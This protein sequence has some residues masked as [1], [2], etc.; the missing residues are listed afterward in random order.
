[1]K[2]KKLCKRIGSNQTINVYD[3]GNLIY[4][5]K[6]PKVAELYG[7]MKVKYVSAWYIEGGC[8]TKITNTIV[9][10]SIHP[11]LWIEIK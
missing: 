1:M 3:N 11:V 9:S 2:V 6:S 8:T 7:D 4:Q 5:G 10:K